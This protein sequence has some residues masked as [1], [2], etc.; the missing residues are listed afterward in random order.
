M[1]IGKRNRQRGGGRPNWDFRTICD[2]QRHRNERL[3]RRV[4]K[5][6]SR[7]LAVLVGLPLAFGALFP[8]ETINAMNANLLA[9]H[10]PE[11][12]DAKKADAEPQFRIFTSD[13]TRAR[14]LAPAP[15]ELMT[16]DQVKEEFFNTQVPYGKIIWREAKRNS[17]PPELVAAVVE[18][19]SDFR[20]RLVS[21][22]NARG[23]MQIVPETGA[24]LGV[25]DPFNP[26]QNIAAGTRYLRYLFNRFADRKLVLAA[27][28]AGE[29]NV[30]KC[31][32]IPQFSETVAYLDRVEIRA[33]RLEAKVHT[34]YLASLQAK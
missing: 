34:T 11:F 29:G 31:Y 28:N 5:I 15:R 8:T 27:Y 30:E 9:I 7:G 13:Q 26:E 19:E 21:N 25:N 16:F 33:H 4:V 32:C 2:C 12:R 23:L 10:R 14:F 3:T 6:A 24:L 17:L 1:N 22:K 20:P 18:A